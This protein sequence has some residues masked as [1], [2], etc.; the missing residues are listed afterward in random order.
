MKNGLVLFLCFSVFFPTLL[1]KDQNICICSSFDEAV[2]NR[3]GPYL[4]VFFSTSCQV[5]W[6]DLIKMKYFLHKQS[7]DITLIGVSRDLK[8]DLERFAEMYSCDCPVI[9]DKKGELYRKYQVNLEPFKLIIGGS[10]VFYRDSYYEDLQKREEKI[11][12]IL[13]KFKS[14]CA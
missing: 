14:K 10:E 2:R 9:Y 3:H 5:C 7:I 1:C 6:E 13:M 12:K 8:E 11:K 4:L